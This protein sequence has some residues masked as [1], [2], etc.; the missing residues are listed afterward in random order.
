MPYLKSPKQE[1]GPGRPSPAGRAVLAVIFA[2]LLFSPPGFSRDLSG[3]EKAPGNP[4][5]LDVV[6][7]GALGRPALFGLETLRQA[8]KAGGI[9]VHERA[10]LGDA[11]SPSVILIGTLQGSSRVRNLNKSGRLPLAGAKES[12]AVHRLKEDGRDLLVIAGADDRGLMYALLDVARQVAS[13]P[14]SKP[15]PL[16]DVIAEASESPHVPV[17]SLALFLHNQDDEKAWYYSREFWQDYFAMLAADR[18]NTFNLVFSHQTPY[19]APMYPFHVAV[20]EYPEVKAEGLTDPQREKNLDMLR[21]I[22]SLAKER[23][24]DFTL[25]VWQQIAW[26]AGENTSAQKSTVSGYDKSNMTGY[27]Y[28]ALKKLL[29]ECPGITGLQLR[30]NYESGVDYGEQTAFFRDAVFR[31]AKEAGR[32]I[33]IEVRD[34]GLLSETL[35]AALETGDPV[36]VSHKYWAEHMV[37]PYHPARFIWTYSYGDWLKYPRNAD[38]IYQ[39]W[40]LGSHRVLLWGDPG[41]VRRFAPTT[42]FEDAVGFEICAPLAQKGYGNAP[43]AWRIFRDPAREYYRWEFERYWSFYQLFGRLTYNPDEGDTVWM[44]ELGRRFGKAASEPVASA[45]RSASRVV[46]LVSA[47]AIGNYNMGA[48]PE[49]DMG[50]LI[51]YYLNLRPYDIARFQGFQEYIDNV[52][53]GRSSGRTSPLELAGTLDAVAAETERS[54]GAAGPLLRGG[55]KE[56]W[57]TDK[58][59]RILS[60]LARYF[61]RK[62]R[63]A[64]ELGFFYRTGDAGRLRRA[65]GHGREALAIWKELSVIADE[66]YSPNLVFG[67]GSVGHWKDNIPFVEDDLRQLEYQEKLFQVVGSADYAFDFG[68]EPG[69]ET[70]ALWST[71]YTNDFTV[72]R[73]FRGVFPG[74]LYDPA[75]GFGWIGGERLAAPAPP[76]VSGY[77]WSGARMGRTGLPKEALLGDYVKGEKEAVFRVDLPEGH[78]QGTVILADRSPQPADHGPMRVIVVERFG[79]RPVLDS[80]VVRAGQ[81]IVKRFNINMTGERFTT[82]RLKFAADPGADFIVSA[83]TFTRV[84]PYIA[85]VPVG[86]AAPGRPLE[87]SACVT[88]PP[89]PNDEHPLTSLG[90]ITSNASTLDVPKDIARVTLKYGQDPGG[91]FAS[92]DMRPDSAVS[93]ATLPAADLKAGTVLYYLEAEDSTG[94]VVRLPQATAVSPYFRVD[95]SDDT[96]APAVVHSPVATHPPGRPLAVRVKV[97]DESPVAKVLLYYRPTRQTMEYAVL[98]MDRDGDGYA[99]TIPGSAI[100]KDFDLMYYFE[101]F[102]RHGNACLYPDPEKTQPYFVVKVER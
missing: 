66:I 32:P 74:S 82:F 38:Q 63:A 13:A 18:W 102:D 95:V 81:T 30:L 86:R 33:L 100:T 56:F 46:S 68:P 16:F 43:G 84:E 47:A 31:A 2:C 28:L 25:S 15:G 60:G 78:Y 21:Y 22:S 20:P 3:G 24:L 98:T 39:V 37:F 4:A 76:R 17:R 36:R 85:H 7:D 90:I 9:P 77:T 94:R 62:I 55:E 10:S 101:A 75:A 19:L 57:A 67:P 61:S 80:T 48:W 53:A 54:L 50:G 99:A 59:F 1:F 92:L 35:D 79:D 41:F 83:L 26:G 72:E 51:N 89:P 14:P 91:P 11:E 71:T 29:R 58:D 44:Q 87:V 64:T 49:K 6:V 45:Y 42:T 97:T 70:T 12:L 8:L 93:S 88:L 27:T 34:I 5:G 52:L 69:T 23:G 73:R 40:S 65:V 96:A